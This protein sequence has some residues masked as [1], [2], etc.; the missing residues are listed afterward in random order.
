MAVN[1]S[2]VVAALLLLGL[3]Y[4]SVQK[5]YPRPLPGI[6]YNRSA[7]KR[8]VG[9]IAEIG[10]HV[11]RGSSFRNWFL[12]QASK[13]N[14][15]ITQVFLGPFEKAGVII[16]DYR[17]VNDILSH[18]DGVDFKRGKKVEA[19]RGLLPHAFPAMETFDARFKSSRD[20]A[21]DLMAPSILHTV[22]R[23]NHPL[24]NATLGG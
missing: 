24:A 1:P 11:K 20:L 12:E 9:D 13:H 3:V 5:A 15:P 6:P 10:E 21:R 18:R 23:V 17:E 16:S 22:R 2:V 4:L 19:F 7:A 14:S 8:L